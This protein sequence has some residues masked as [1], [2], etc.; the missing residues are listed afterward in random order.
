MVWAVPYLSTVV[1]PSLHEGLQVTVPKHILVVSMLNWLFEYFCSC[2]GI[3][4]PSVRHAVWGFVSNMALTFPCNQMFNWVPVC[5]NLQALKV[6]LQPGDH[7]SRSTAMLYAITQWIA[8]IH[9]I[10]GTYSTTST[11]PKLTAEGADTMDFV[12]SMFCNFTS[13]ILIMLVKVSYT[14]LRIGI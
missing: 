11:I 12:A 4:G 7:P 6:Y 9:S 14:N 8:F 2:L 13:A 1:L 3:Y 10:L 5:S